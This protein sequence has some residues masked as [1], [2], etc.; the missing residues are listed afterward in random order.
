M[1]VQCQECIYLKS[2]GIMLQIKSDVVRIYKITTM[3]RIVS[4][5]MKGINKAIDTKLELQMVPRRR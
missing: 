4:P 1:K 5:C 3:G 2:S